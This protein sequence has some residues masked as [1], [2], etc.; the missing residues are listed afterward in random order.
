M[1]TPK[2]VRQKARQQTWIK[3]KQWGEVF[4]ILRKETGRSYSVF[5]WTS[6]ILGS[7]SERK[8][9]DSLEEGVHEFEHRLLLVNVNIIPPLNLSEP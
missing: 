2:I 3:Y 1:L 4:L 6:N 9:F 8:Y 7:Y 5:F